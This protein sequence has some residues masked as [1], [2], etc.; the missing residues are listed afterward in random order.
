MDIRVMG[1]KCPD[2]S[3]GVRIEL[4]IEDTVGF[5]QCHINLTQEQAKDMKLGIEKAL[6]EAKS[7][8]TTKRPVGQLRKETPSP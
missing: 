3:L 5:G 7:L 8:T 4:T 6:E 2:Q 1:I